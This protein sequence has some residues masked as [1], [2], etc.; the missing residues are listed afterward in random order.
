MSPRLRFTKKVFENESVYKDNQNIGIR[1]PDPK[2]N[3]K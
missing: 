3:K 1:C 2:E